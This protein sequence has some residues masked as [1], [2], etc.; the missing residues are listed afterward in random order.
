MEPLNM[1]RA[2][3]LSGI[4]PQL[5]MHVAHKDT[6]AAISSDGDI[7]KPPQA[8]GV[9]IVHHAG[10]LLAEGQSSA[11]RRVLLSSAGKIEDEETPTS[12]KK[13]S[14]DAQQHEEIAAST[15]HQNME[16]VGEAY[17]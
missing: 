8:K 2:G 10:E 7:A 1:D 4:A 6:Y 12:K 9:S 5:M 15:G 11:Q 13:A 16:A 3:E 17:M 14:T